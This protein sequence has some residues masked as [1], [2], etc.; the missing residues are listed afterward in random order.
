MPTRRA[1]LGWI[2]AGTTAAIAGRVAAALDP[3]LGHALQ[4]RRPAAVMAPGKLDEL[5][6]LVEEFK[7]S[8]SATPAQQLYADLLATRA[9]VGDVLD[10]SLT[11]GEHRDL[12]AIAG[13]LSALLGLACFDLG[14]YRAARVWCDDAWDRAIEA[15]HPEVAAWSR[16][17]LTIMWFYLGRAADAVAAAQQGLTV[18]PDG[19]VVQAKL[20]AAEMRSLARFGP[21]R[22]REFTDARRRAESAVDRLPVAT[23]GFTFR[24]VHKPTMPLFTVQS[25]LMLGEYGEAEPI[26]RQ[27]IELTKTETSPAGYALYRIEHALALAGLGH[28]DGAAALGMQALDSRRQLA[29]VVARA[30]ELDQ[31]LQR[32]FPGTAE[33][34]DFHE[35]YLAARR[36]LEAED[37]GLPAQGV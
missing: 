12:L 26:A 8:Y 32:Q 15:A 6:G 24:A 10:G 33:A 17:P 30:G 2:S 4:A 9:H 35:R 27:L 19:S 28:A 29:P 18:A 36:S 7:V 25:L 22:K 31:A 13:W 21:D 14:R 5:G 34:R 20:A 37:A 16:E 23:E 11:L 1:V 3:Y